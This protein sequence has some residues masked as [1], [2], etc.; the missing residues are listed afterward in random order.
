MR[1]R[2]LVSAGVV[3]LGVAAAAAPAIAVPEIASVDVWL[4]GTGQQ[5]CLA[6]VDRFMNSLDIRRESGSVDRTG[7]FA[8]GSFR[9]ICYGDE[10]DSFAV[11][12]AAHESDLSVATSFVQYAAEQIQR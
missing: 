6:Q 3:S 5:G 12:F 10:R 8:D 4:R 7:Y 9:I 1:F 11:I 2:S